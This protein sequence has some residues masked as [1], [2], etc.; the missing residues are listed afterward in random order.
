[1]A[2][3]IGNVVVGGSTVKGGIDENNG[4]QLAQGVAAVAHE[5]TDT[6]V[7]TARRLG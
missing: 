1:M 7:T 6:I 2:G 4:L 5:A 3:N